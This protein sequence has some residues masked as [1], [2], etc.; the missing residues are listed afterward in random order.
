[1]IPKELE[2][3]SAAGDLFSGPVTIKWEEGA[4]APVG[5]FYHT[6]LWLNGLVYVGGGIET[7][8][9]ASFTI[10]C[11]NPVN[12]SWCS[13]NT[14]Y[15]LF[16]MTSLSSSLLIAGGQ[17]KSEK[18]TNQ[19]LTMNAGQL[20]NYTKMITARSWATATGHQGMLI[21][22]GGRDDSNK[23]LSSTELFDS[24]HGQWYTCND[25]PQPH[26]HLKSVVVDN[27][28]YLLGGINKHYNPSSEVFTAQLDRLSE[29]Q[30]KWN[31][32][33][34]TPWSLSAPVII[35]NM[36][37]LIAGGYQLKGYVATPNIYKLNKISQSW[38]AIGQIP[39][40]RSSAAAVST[41][42]N[43]VIVIG[44]ANYMEKITNKVWIGSCEP[45]K[46]ST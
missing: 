5:R 31:T 19:I 7:K 45:Q 21:I 6:A 43:T 32:H 34:D 10:D 44:G 17:D 9:N 14:P 11:Y 20:K 16:A 39:S 40:T 26:S 12:D 13:I 3:T 41:A 35:N 15:C 25:L 24:N 8:F 18:G 23:I 4:P 38:E 37:L 33:K 42:D 46:A 2:S 27:I 1:M 28:L 36:H 30:L 22:T 29:H